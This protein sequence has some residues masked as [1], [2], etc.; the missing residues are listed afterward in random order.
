MQSHWVKVLRN[1]VLAASMKW[2]KTNVRD[3]VK[4][5]FLLTTVNIL[6]TSSVTLLIK[7][8]P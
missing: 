4:T 7:M 8:C 6:S 3:W 2:D 5:L 1:D